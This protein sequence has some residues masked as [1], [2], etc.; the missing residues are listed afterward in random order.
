MDISSFV[1]TTS[2]DSSR[3]ETINLH[4]RQPENISSILAERGKRCKKYAFS[5][6]LNLIDTQTLV[7]SLMG[8]LL[9]IYRTRLKSINYRPK[10]DTFIVP[11]SQY[12][13]NW[14][15]RAENDMIKKIDTGWTLSVLY[16]IYVQK[17]PKSVYL[18]ILSG[19]YLYLCYRGSINR[20]SV[21]FQNDTVHFP[22][23]AGVC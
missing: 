22:T 8:K 11:F 21:T 19:H 2:L 7:N 5:N 9:R 6:S 14:P 16:Q 3:H 1:L 10:I 15:Y 13:G 20:L 17:W 18:L 23:S 4:L 12:K